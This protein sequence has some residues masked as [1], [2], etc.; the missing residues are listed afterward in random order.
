MIRTRQIAMSFLLSYIC[1]GPVCA[2]QS[3]TSALTPHIAE[4]TYPNTGDGLWTFLEKLRTASK[5]A[6]PAAFEAL[7]KQT[8]IPDDRAWFHRMYAANKADS[9]IPQYEVEL[10]RNE[11]SLRQLFVRFASKKAQIMIRN[12]NDNPEP[13][14]GLE[15]GLLHSAR[16]P[17]NVYYAEWK[18]GITDDNGA[19][20]IG[21]FFYI[22]GMFRW[23]SLIHFM[24]PQTLRPDSPSTHASAQTD[25]PAAG[26]IYHAD[27]ST[28]PPKLLSSVQAKYTDRARKKH[29]EGSVLLTVVVDTNGHT[30][31]IEISRSLETDLDEQAIE[32]L[33]SY[34]FSPALKNGHPV[35]VKLAIEVQFHLYANR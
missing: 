4:E 6:D 35:A 32:A 13:G 8:E 22:D 34:T 33:R 24:G 1:I 17:L 27:K 7:V 9:W 2:Q 23:D 14:K 3:P 19:E 28:T 12:V 11:A 26:P 30:K 29:L 16:A 25:L 18:P 5:A 10:T 21:Y 15:W 20:P 31:D